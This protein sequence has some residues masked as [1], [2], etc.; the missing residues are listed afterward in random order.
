MVMNGATTVIVFPQRRVAEFDGLL[1][2]LENRERFFERLDPALR[3]LAVLQPLI[4]MPSHLT[5]ARDAM[6]AE[7]RR[8]VDEAKARG[9]EMME[10]HVPAGEDLVEA[11]RWA[12]PHVEH[13]QRMMIAELLPENVRDILALWIQA[14]QI[15]CGHLGV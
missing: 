13:A 7:S 4:R 1:E 14:W 6:L 2:F 9:M 15:I 10:I 5:P 8:Q 12:K 3:E 11:A